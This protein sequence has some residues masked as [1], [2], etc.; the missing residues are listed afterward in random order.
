MDQTIEEIE[1]NIRNSI[2]YFN[3][4]PAINIIN[5]NTINASAMRN[6]LTKT[7]LE[8]KLKNIR[9]IINEE[10]KV[11]I[12]NVPNTVIEKV[13]RSDDLKKLESIRERKPATALHDVIAIYYVRE[14]RN[15]FIANHKKAKTW[16][17]T[18]NDGLYNFDS[19]LVPINYAPEVA[20]TEDLA[21]LLW[22]KDID[23]G[24]APF[25]K[26][27]LNE[28]ISR[29]LVS[30]L[31]DYKVLDDLYNNLRK[32]KET[33]PETAH[34]LMDS[35]AHSSYKEIK[36]L[37]IIAEKRPDEFLH[38]IDKLSQEKRLENEIVHKRLIET[39]DQELV[40]ADKINELIQ[41]NE[42]MEL[43]IKNIENEIIPNE[44]SRSIALEVT[45]K[46][47]EKSNKI[48]KRIAI[49]AICTPLLAITTYFVFKYLSG[50]IKIIVG[51]ISGLGGFWGFI[52]L[53]I[54]VIK[55]IIKK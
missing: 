50:S 11:K 3:T 26:L 8:L 24:N 41:K 53:V 43:M 49:G 37:N 15:G 17:V 38:K 16:F 6:G 48:Y 23:K 7:D 19:S 22:I 12:L 2:E 13:K 45:V 34:E 35:L 14:L 42:K 46:Q 10:L 21:F 33:D 28:Y 40:Y 29:V 20:L 44:K 39:K 25:L 5:N 52:N 1:F 30:G 18:D 54:N 31:P 36:L 4:N 55:S 9:K 27:G 51:I 32:Y 47:M